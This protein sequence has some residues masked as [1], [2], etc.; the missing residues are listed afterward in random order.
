MAAPAVWV[1]AL[2]FAASRRK[3]RTELKLFWTAAEL[4]GCRDAHADAL[5]VAV[6]HADGHSCR[7]PV[8]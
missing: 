1:A 8:A 4:V 2:C 7:A 6:P 5:V 3:P